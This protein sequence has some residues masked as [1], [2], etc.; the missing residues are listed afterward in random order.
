[1]R[2]GV[3]RASIFYNYKSI[4]GRRRGCDVATRER[5]QRPTS[6]HTPW[7]ESSAHTEYAFL[8][9]ASPAFRTRG[10]LAPQRPPGPDPRLVTSRVVSKKSL[11]VAFLM[12]NAR[13]VLYT[14]ASGRTGLTLAG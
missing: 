12:K 13:L 8:H 3:E 5:V 4:L 2:P 6:V 10:P 1:M 14:A 7:P 11:S 9:P